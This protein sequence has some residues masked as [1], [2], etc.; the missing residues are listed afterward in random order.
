MP[1]SLHILYAYKPTKWHEMSGKSL[2]TE[3][4]GTDLQEC[5]AAGVQKTPKGP[6]GAGPEVRKVGDFG[7]I[8]AVFCRILTRFA[9]RGSIGLGLGMRRATPG[10]KIMRW[11]AR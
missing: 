3:Q 1:I 10:E 7:R 9:R 2:Q 11:S 6:A 4:T 8:L 5:L